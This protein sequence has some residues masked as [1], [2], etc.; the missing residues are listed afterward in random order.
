MTPKRLARERH[1]YVHAEESMNV[2]TNIPHKGDR[3]LPDEA[4][5]YLIRKVAEIQA[6]QKEFKRSWR[7]EYVLEHREQPPALHFALR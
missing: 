5:T 7:E 1:L 4:K 6:L 3:P 2:I